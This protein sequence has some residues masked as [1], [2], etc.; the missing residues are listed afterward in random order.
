MFNQYGT[1]VTF[2]AHFVGTTV[3]A[4]KKSIPFLNYYLFLGWAASISLVLILSLQNEQA[5]IFMK[6]ILFIYF[7]L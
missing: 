5:T 6:S 7:W 3:Q 2:V 1:Q 4:S